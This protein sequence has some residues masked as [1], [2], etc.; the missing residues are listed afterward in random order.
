[1][2][3]NDGELRGDQIG[4]AAILFPW[5]RRRNYPGIVSGLGGIGKQD[6]PRAPAV[7]DSTV[8]KVSRLLAP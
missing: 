8:A 1:V 7:Q 2:S 4:Q 3:P 5:C 6:S